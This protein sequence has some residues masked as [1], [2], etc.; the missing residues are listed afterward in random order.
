MITFRRGFK[1]QLEADWHWKLKG[2]FTIARN[3]HNRYYWVSTDGHLGAFAGCAW[4]GA[5]FFPDYRWILEGSLGHD[6]LHWLIAKGII[7]ESQNDLIDKELA[8]IIKARAPLPRLLPMPVA[9]KLLHARAWMVRK[10]TNL[11]NQKSGDVR[12]LITIGRR[13]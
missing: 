5:T 1:Y 3:Y 10:G 9:I 12:P 11:V 13:E 4:D 2:D 8:E 7:P 6:L